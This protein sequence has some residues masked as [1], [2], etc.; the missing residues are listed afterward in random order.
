VTIEAARELIASRTLTDG[1]L[2]ALAA[3]LSALPKPRRHGLVGSRPIAGSE[4]DQRVPEGVSNPLWEI[5]RL[6]PGDPYYGPGERIDPNGH[7]ASDLDDGAM[8][9]AH[10]AGLG[11]SGLCARYS[12]S[13]PSPGDMAWLRQMLDGQ[14]IVE[15]GAG[16]GYWAWQLAQVGVAVAAYDPV[17]P[18]PDNS[19]NQHKL[20]HPVAEGDHGKAAE[21]PGRALM[22][23]WPSCGASFA[24][25]A[26]H[27]YRGD[28]VIYIG[29]DEGGCCADE[30]FHRILR[31]DFEHV[32]SSPKHVTYWGIH[33]DLSVWR[34]R[35]PKAIAAADQ[36]GDRE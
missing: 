7:W 17:P 33:C 13:I 18:G 32:G 2:I 12:W 9:R 10:A 30:R 3:E 4:Q 31:R 1:E 6:M 23:C 24:K 26:L 14:S 34:R 21:H 11:R 16:S 27:H 25:E 36:T 22:L 35:G 8:R 28:T 5:V 15:I 29:E 20:Y 19:F